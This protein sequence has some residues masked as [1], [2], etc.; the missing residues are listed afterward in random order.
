[1]SD[2]CL[3]KRAE[4]AHSRQVAAFELEPYLGGRA[5]TFNKSAVLKYAVLKYAVLK[6]AAADLIYPANQEVTAGTL[7]R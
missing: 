5:I 3:K 7:S 2:A 1:M 4:Q 6:Y